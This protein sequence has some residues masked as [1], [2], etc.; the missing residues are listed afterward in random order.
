MMQARSQR[1]PRVCSGQKKKV[2]KSTLVLVVVYYKHARALTFQNLFFCL[3][4]QGSDFSDLF[5]LFPGR[6]CLRT[7]A[8]SLF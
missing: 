8:S 6:A 4:Y 1:V 7:R 2:L 5:F 3:I